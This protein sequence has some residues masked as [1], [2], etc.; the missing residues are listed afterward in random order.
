M[1]LE[2]EVWLSP[3]CSEEFQ[4]RDYTPVTADLNI[5]QGSDAEFSENASCE[6]GAPV[7][8]SIQ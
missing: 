4:S 8:E 3:I 7:A 5:G 6:T 1:R 2:R